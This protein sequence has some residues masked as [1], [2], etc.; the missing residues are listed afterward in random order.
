[1][2]AEFGKTIPIEHV[3]KLAEERNVKVEEVEENVGQSEE[4]IFIAERIRRSFFQF[5]PKAIVTVEEKEGAIAEKA[6][7]KKSG[8]SIIFILFTLLL[9]LAIIA[10]IIWL[11]LRYR[12]TT[13]DQR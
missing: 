6:V 10:V 3:I 11:Y 4:T 13:K 12:R 5:I 8:Y 2:E 9:L 7:T 1:M